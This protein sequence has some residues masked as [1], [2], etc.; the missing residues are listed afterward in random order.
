MKTAHRLVPLKSKKKGASM[1]WDY[2]VRCGL[3]ALNNEAT[4]RALTMLCDAEDEQ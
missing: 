3:V 2:C 4:R 1:P